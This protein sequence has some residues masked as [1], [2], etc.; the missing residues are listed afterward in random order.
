MSLEFI[1]KSLRNQNKLR[2]IFFWQK[3]DQTPRTIF[4]VS[5]LSQDAYNLVNRYYFGTQKCFR[6]FLLRILSQEIWPL[7]CILGHKMIII[8][9]NAFIFTIL[10]FMLLFILIC[11]LSLDL[12]PVF[13][14]SL[15]LQIEI[16][17][18]QETAA[19]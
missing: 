8:L 13:V 15:Q 3:F 16:I 1:C 2:M 12:H 11:L 6:P 19:L 9:N 4:Q 10:A 7:I 5:I 17:F 18:W 14:F